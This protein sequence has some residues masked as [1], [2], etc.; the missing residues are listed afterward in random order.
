VIIPTVNSEG[1]ILNTLREVKDKL[2]LY[3]KIGLLSDFEILP[4][5]QV[6]DDATF[7]LLHVYDNDD[8]I[9]PHYLSIRGKGLACSYGMKKSKMSHVL[10]FDSDNDYP[11]SFL[12][13]AIPLTEK[14]DFVIA[15]R[16]GRLRQ[17]LTRKIASKGYRFLARRLFNV[18]GIYDLQAGEKLFDR[19]VFLENIDCNNLV[20]GFCWDT[21]VLH[22]AR[23]KGLKICEV[24]IVYSYHQNFLQVSSAWYEMF[25]ELVKLRFKL[26]DKN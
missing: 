3:K 18:S 12:L 11:I 5:A 26:D 25:L 24:S 7:A 1:H 20:K 6:S 15:S 19:K 9:H 8:I 17:P 22:L 21:Q 4:I 10:T 2:F 23:E 16:V 14:Y 13:D